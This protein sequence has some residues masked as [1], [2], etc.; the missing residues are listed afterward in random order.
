M[1]M[2]MVLIVV[3]VV[4]VVVGVAVVVVVVTGSSARAGSS[5]ISPQFGPALPRVGVLLMKVQGSQHG[6]A[7]V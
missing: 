1:T 6:R 3:V 7:L 5:A 4:V 2:K